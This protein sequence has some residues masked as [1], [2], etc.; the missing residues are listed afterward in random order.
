MERG[1]CHDDVNQIMKTFVVV[2]GS[3]AISGDYE[4][5]VRKV[6]LHT[7][8]IAIGTHSVSVVCPDEAL[9]A[10]QVKTFIVGG[11]DAQPWKVARAC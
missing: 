4:K 7:G 2:D 9:Y 11:R 10:A 6:D 8:L 1:V 3:G 5:G